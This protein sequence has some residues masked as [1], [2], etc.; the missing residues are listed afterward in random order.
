MIEFILLVFT[1]AFQMF[2]GKQN[3]SVDKPIQIKDSKDYAILQ[4]FLR[5]GFAEEEDYGYVLAGIKPISVRNFQALDSFL[6][7][8]YFDWE[9]VV[10][11]AVLVW[12]RV[13]PNKRNFVFK[14]AYPS[15]VS[16]IRSGFELQ[17]INISLLRNVIEENIALFRYVLGPFLTTDQLVSR[18]A[19][20]N[21]LL[22]DVLKDNSTLIGIVL[23]FGLQNSLVGGKIETLSSNVL[24][25]DEA[26][27][28]PQHQFFQSATRNFFLLPEEIYRFYY[29]EFAGGDESCFR[30]K[31]TS[32]H[33]GLNFTNLN[34]ELKEIQTREEALPLSLNRNPRFVFAAFS[35]PT[36]NQVLFEKLQQA[37][38][39]IHSLLKKENFLEIVLEKI[40]EKKPIITCA[41]NSSVQLFK[42]RENEW[43]EH[44]LSIAKKFDNRRQQLFINA[45]CYPTEI[46][47]KRPWA[48]GVSQATLLGL[49]RARSNLAMADKQFAEFAKKRS[50]QFKEI[51]RSLL[52]IETIEQG[53]GKQ[54]TS[55][56]DR[57]RVSYVIEDQKGEIL[58]ANHDTWLHIGEV[59]IGFAHGIQGMFIGESRTL[60]IHP[61]I[62]YGALTTLPSCSSLVVK[63][64]L[65]DIDERNPCNK[66]LSS[67]NP[68]DLAWVNDSEFYNKIH[69]SLEQ[70]PSYIGSFYRD[71]LDK[72][73]DLNVNA[74]MIALQ[75]S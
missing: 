1:A 6:V 72:R 28:L 8:N 36:A 31:P 2:F 16:S 64:H 44:L 34:E 50:L 13:C 66:S 32:I 30:D 42:Q 40:S 59:I 15:G 43:S 4:E 52:Y 65:L 63:V 45:F 18:I 70:I 53:K 41:K 74:L 12:N 37:Q 11:E 58:F 33:L 49:N 69:E 55:K 47:R 17:F 38:K 22:S 46:S 54:I 24:V 75:E 5:R 35:G 3:V 23:G 48:V 62:A 61:A 39:W 19:H 20:S 67:I 68:H 56:I 14:V 73:A 27:F 51:V 29:L 57:I 21:E 25:K 26:P 7:P 9:L 10:H 60:Y 71:W